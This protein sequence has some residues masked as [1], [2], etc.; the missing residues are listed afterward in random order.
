MALPSIFWVL[1]GAATGAV[2]WERGLGCV[3]GCLVGCFRPEG[4]KSHDRPQ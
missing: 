2:G 1:Q 4:I 3:P